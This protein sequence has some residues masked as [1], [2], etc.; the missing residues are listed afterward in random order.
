MIAGT[1]PAMGGLRHGA[2]AIALGVLSFG[3]FGCAEDE[4][5]PAGSGHILLVTVDTLRADHMGLYGYARATTPQID[6]FFG[7]RGRLFLRAYATSAYTSPSVVSV[8][9]GLLPQDHRVRL[10]LQLLGDE[11]PLL[12]EMLP[13]PYESA[14]FVSNSVLTD[15]AMGIGHRFDHYD[16][17]VGER[18]ANRA[19]F[20]RTARRTTD[21][22]LRWLRDERDPD[23]PLFLWVHYIDPHGPYGPPEE[24]PLRFSHDQPLP[25]DIARVPVVQRRRG[26]DDGLDYVDRYDEE[27]AYADAQIGRLFDAWAEIGPVDDSLVLFTAD[28]GET[29][30]EHERWFDHGY[31]VYE[32]LVR[33]PLLLR[34]YGVPPGRSE[35]L[36]SGV[37]LVPTILGFAGAPV[38]PALPG[39]DLRDPEA[40]ASDR[41]VFAEARRWRTAIQGDRKWMLEYR[42]GR[43]EIMDRRFYDLAR[44]PGEQSPEPWQQEGTTT[45]WLLE[46][47]ER[48]P[49]P[50]GYPHDPRRGHKLEAPKISPHATPE[51][52]EQ[53]RALGYV[54]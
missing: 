6:R 45:R 20:E 14:A 18:E 36:V 27:I 23:R 3:A 29:L 13:A 51:Q 21:A 1:M 17:F 52:L 35:A 12:S 46:L 26:Q 8:L 4:A 10:F 49:D 43:R 9:T 33:V 50:G 54:E 47:G 38:D 53:L 42:Q 25:I 30:M 48:D 22:V 28:H 5:G 34:G 41:A 37:D 44:D 31:H 2:L 32:E 19:A 16:D 40:I 7:E 15:E 39:F 11:I 24:P